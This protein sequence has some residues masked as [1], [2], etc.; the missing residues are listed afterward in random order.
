MII[1]SAAWHLEGEPLKERMLMRIQT[2]YGALIP[3]LHANNLL[4]DKSF[5]T[6]ISDWSKFEIR[7]SDLTEEG[8]ELFKRCHDIWLG[9]LDRAKD[10]SKARIDLW[11]KEL[12]KLQH[13]RNRN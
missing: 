13:A 12:A 10:K 3:F 5:G 9:A 11:E 6:N 8:D 1:D 7:V 2:S 4:R